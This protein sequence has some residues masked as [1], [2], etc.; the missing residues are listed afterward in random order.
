MTKL[1]VPPVP[2][3]ARAEG[4]TRDEMISYWLSY[5]DANSTPWNYLSSTRAVKQGYK[6]LHRLSAL[7]AACAREKTKQGRSSNEEVVKLAAPVAFGRSTQVFD[8]PRRQFA[9]GRDLYSGYRVPF[10]FV[11]DGTVKL[12]YLQPRKGYALNREQIAMVATIHKTF[13]LDNEFYGTKSDVEYIDV[14]ADPITGVRIV[15]HFSL[16]SIELWSPSR[17]Q[18][19]LTLIAESLDFVRNSELVRPKRRTIRRPESDLPLF[20]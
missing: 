11:E 4:S 9:F 13:L 18:D 3:L 12:F 2:E 8:L 6:G 19:R 17:L 15:K 5:Y 16:D 14:S 20:D 7:V 1:P 10:F